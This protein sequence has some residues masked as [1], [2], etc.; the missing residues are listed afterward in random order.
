MGKSFILKD[1]AGS[2]AGY[3][4]EGLGVMR[5]RVCGAKAGMQAII[6][7]A[8]QTIRRVDAAPDGQEKEWTHDG[9]EPAGAAI[10][11]AEGEIVADSGARARAAYDAYRRKDG[12]AKMNLRREETAQPPDSAAEKKAV[13]DLRTTGR[14]AQSAVMPPETESLP[15]RRWPPPPCWESAVYQQ[16]RWIQGTSLM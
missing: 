7:Y 2:A 3:L 11:S 5:L 8:D 4:T 10:I 15:E 9:K 12:G 1:R 14:P 16:G 13:P 6:L